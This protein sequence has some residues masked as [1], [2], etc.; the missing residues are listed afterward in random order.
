M[1]NLADKTRGILSK[2]KGVSIEDN[3]AASNPSPETLDLLLRRRSLVA[4]QMV[5]PGPNEEQIEQLLTIGSRVP[6]H[7]RLIPWRFL[8]FQGQYRADFGEI[9]AKVYQEN[10]P[11]DKPERIELER[12]R[13][14][15]APLVI[16]VVSSPDLDNTIPEW[17]QILTSGAVCQNILIA[18]HAMGFASQWLSEWYAYDKRIKKALGLEKH[19]A[20][21]GFMYIGSVGGEP[22]ER[23][24]PNLK[25]IVMN[26]T[27]PKQTELTP[28]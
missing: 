16:A 9:L 12:Q 24:R 13:F 10:N 4:N 8:I 27:A 3:V 21:A 23:K 18:A 22:S 20:I 19:E 15:R 14:S 1:L 6:D 26:W 28:N 5:F 7:K 11:N 17:E 25:S 2:M